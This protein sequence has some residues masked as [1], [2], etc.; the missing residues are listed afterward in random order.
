[1][2]FPNGTMPTLE[3]VHSAPLNEAIAALVVAAIL[4]LVRTRVRPA[5]L[6]GMYAI[7][8]GLARLLVEMVRTN[9][10]VV[11]GL[12]QPQLWSIALIAVGVDLNY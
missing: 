5:V 3:R 8:S 1:M 4:W 11:A 2:S 12:T 10:P 9:E 7:L 6:F